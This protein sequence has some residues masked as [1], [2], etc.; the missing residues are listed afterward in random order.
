MEL[1]FSQYYAFVFETLD[2]ESY[3]RQ[4]DISGRTQ[5]ED[6]ERLPVASPENKRQHRAVLCLGQ[7]D[8]PNFANAS[9]V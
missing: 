4:V 2:D 8:S 1:S 9:T 7:D 5:Q 6:P 3:G